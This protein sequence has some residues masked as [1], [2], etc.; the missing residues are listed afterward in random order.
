MKFWKR[1][2]ILIGSIRA[3]TVI[4]L[5]INPHFSEALTLLCDGIDSMIAYKAGMSWAKYTRYDKALDYWWY[6][7]VLIYCIHTPI[8]A[9]MLV[10]FVIRS[11][12]QIA[13]LVSSKHEL[14]FWFPNVFENY[15]IIYLLV[16]LFTPG[17]VTYFSGWAIAIPLFIAFITKM[18]QEYMLHRKGW[19]YDPNKWAKSITSTIKRVK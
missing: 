19:F 12:G 2:L 18:P 7:F 11:V 1:V 10:L 15:F 4:I 6:I 13:T 3:L 8:F 16:T 9:V 14:L 5:F 17:Y